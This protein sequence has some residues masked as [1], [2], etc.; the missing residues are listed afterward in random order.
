MCLD[1]QCIFSHEG[2]QSVAARNSKIAEL[3][4]H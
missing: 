1:V 4:F 2:F 3:A